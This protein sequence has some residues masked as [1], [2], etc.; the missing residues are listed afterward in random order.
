MPLALIS[1]GLRGYLGFTGVVCLGV[2]L[3]LFSRDK[4][5]MKWITFLAYAACWLIYFLAPS[6]M[7]VTV[8]VQVAILVYLAYFLI[9]YEGGSTHW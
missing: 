2:I 5:W 9:V 4:T 8:C 6:L 7:L 3:H 1:V